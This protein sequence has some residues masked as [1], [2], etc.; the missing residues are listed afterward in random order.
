M[1][2]GDE[3]YKVF[4]ELVGAYRVRRLRGWVRA[5]G[6]CEVIDNEELVL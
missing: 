1:D 2:S 3:E 4:E 5:Y 6:G